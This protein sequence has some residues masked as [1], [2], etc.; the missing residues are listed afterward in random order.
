MSIKDEVE[1]GRR[2]ERKTVWRTGEEPHP[3]ALK[4]VEE[5]QCDWST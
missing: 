2:G 4:E 1:G 3:S 5:S